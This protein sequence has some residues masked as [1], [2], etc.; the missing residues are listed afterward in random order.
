MSISDCI[1]ECID[2]GELLELLPFIT[3]AVCLRR[4]LVN[5]DVLNFLTTQRRIPQIL[6]K[7]AIDARV[8]LDSFTRGAE[9]TVAMDPFDKPPET[10]LARNKDVQDAVWDFRIRD[11]R[12]QVRIFGRFATKDTFVALHFAG[13]DN[14]NFP[15]AVKNTVQQWIDLFGDLEPVTGDNIDDYLSGNY[16]LV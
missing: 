3:G 1:Q 2:G 4:V 10:E 15:R 8:A 5:H 12:P 6:A 7:K 9:L 16:Q 11:P 13:R 14:L